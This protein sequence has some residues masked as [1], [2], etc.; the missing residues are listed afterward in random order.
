MI[1]LKH[2]FPVPR[3]RV[4]QAWATASSLCLWD[5]DRVE[6]EIIAGHSIAMHWDSLGAQVAVDV[7]SRV[8]EE[9]LSLRSVREGGVC[10]RQT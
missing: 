8:E 2:L 10:M 6:G 7:L 1:T 9:E 4:W 5:P 3:A